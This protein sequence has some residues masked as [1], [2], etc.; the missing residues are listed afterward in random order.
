MRAVR[1]VRQMKNAQTNT[2]QEE[3]ISM[4]DFVQAARLIQVH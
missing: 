2:M 4:D 1:R 3:V